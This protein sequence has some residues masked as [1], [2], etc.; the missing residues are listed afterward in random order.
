[1][2]H[3]CNNAVQKGHVEESPWP[4]WGADGNVW[5]RVQLCDYLTSERGGIDGDAGWGER[6]W[7]EQ[8]APDI[9]SLAINTLRAAEGEIIPHPGSFELYGFDLILDEQLK[10][11]LLEVRHGIGFLIRVPRCCFFSHD[12]VLTRCSCCWCHVL[13]VDCLRTH[14]DNGRRHVRPLVEV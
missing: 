14:D 3:L 6:R 11:W 7:R 1:M 12:T 2:A 8:I 4:E 9:E 5:S 13:I 10:P